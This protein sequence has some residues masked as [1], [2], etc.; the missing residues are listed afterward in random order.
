MLAFIR[1]SKNVCARTRILT[2]FLLITDRA[3]M[4]KKVVGSSFLH[5]L[6]LITGRILVTYDYVQQRAGML[7]LPSSSSCTADETWNSVLNI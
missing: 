1:I 5:D 4:G 2:F 7:S 6:L 3:A